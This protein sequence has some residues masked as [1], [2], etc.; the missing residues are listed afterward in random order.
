MGKERKAPRTAGELAKLQKAIAERVAEGK[1][2]RRV[3][4]ELG[5]S[6][7]LVSYHMGQMR[8]NQTCQ[9]CGRTKKIKCRGLC[10]SCYYQP[11]IKALYAK[12]KK[13]SAKGDASRPSFP[14]SMDP[15]LYPCDRCV[16]GAAIHPRG[17]CPNCFQICPDWQP[18]ASTTRPLELCTAATA[19]A[20]E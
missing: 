9:G 8:R 13:F 12:D 1:T 10:Q 11:E 5:V 3:A 15:G 18:K 20:Q 17:L 4:T 6:K 2:Y 19:V 7:D 16:K 14:W